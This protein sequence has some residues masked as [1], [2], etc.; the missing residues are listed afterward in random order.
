MFDVSDTKRIPALSSDEYNFPVIFIKAT[1]LVKALG[2]GG[3]LETKADGGA[4]D[5]WFAPEWIPRDMVTLV[6]SYRQR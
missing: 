6:G 1:V 2:L 5:E 3:T 4:R